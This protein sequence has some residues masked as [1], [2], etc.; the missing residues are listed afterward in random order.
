M[1]DRFLTLYKIPNRLYCKGSPIIIESG[2]LRKDSI[3]ENLFVQLKFKS[4][5]DKNILAVIIDL[6]GISVTNE[7]L[8]IIS[9]Q[10]LD[11]NCPSYSSFGSNKA[12]IINN[13]ITRQFRIKNLQ[14]VLD[15]GTLWK[16][17]EDELFIDIPEQ[18]LLQKSL[19]PELYQLYL[20][21][22]RLYKAAVEPRRVADLWLCT[23]GEINRKDVCHNCHCSRQTVLES[24][25][26]KILEG[27]Y[28]R[29][30]KEREREQARLQEEAERKQA[31]LQEETE[32]KQAR[33]QEETERKLAEVLK[34]E[35]AR[36]LGID[37]SSE[38][39]S[40]QINDEE[41][42]EKKTFLSRNRTG[43]PKEGVVTFIWHAIIVFVGIYIF[44]LLLIPLSNMLKLATLEELFTELFAFYPIIAV[45]YLISALLCIF[46]KNPTTMT[47]Y[48]II[49]IAFHVVTVLTNGLGKWKKSVPIILYIIL[50]AIIDFCRIFLFYKRINPEYV[51]VPENEKKNHCPNCGVLLLG[52][53]NVCPKCHINI[54]THTRIK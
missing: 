32:R 15:D 22:H 12:I 30:Q 3:S 46:F 48:F 39:Q 50:I 17:S 5:S 24:C 51:Y 21:E 23:C 53:M 54:R 20:S 52:G 35:K 45:S 14:V 36:D 33:L 4:L 16:K 19:A 1:N 8:D 2:Y 18:V 43:K 37:F 7:E 38:N 25:D 49:T 42:S 47:A 34:E 6:I 27:K 29:L 26:P 41:I 11:L 31:R 40:V 44:L 10:Y 9:Y 28:V 13:K